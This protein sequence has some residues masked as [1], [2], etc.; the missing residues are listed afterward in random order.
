MKVL[1]TTRFSTTD[2]EFINSNLDTRWTVLSGTESDMSQLIEQAKDADAMLGFGVSKE[3]LNHAKQL[4][5]FQYPSA[6]VDR[7]D[8]SDFSRR[9]ILLC[10]SHSNSQVVAEHC[11]A[12]L[13]N[14]TR[15]ITAHH[16][17]A[18]KGLRYRFDGSSNDKNYDSI[19]LAGMKIGLLGFGHI[20]STV[21]SLLR[22]FKVEL[23][24]YVRPSRIS[25]KNV[26]SYVR[27]YAS[28]RELFSDV[29]V[30]INSLPLT[31][32][33]EGLI[34]DEL[35]GLMKKDALFINV[36]R[37]SVV[38]EGSLYRSLS[39]GIIKGAAIDVWYSDSQLLSDNYAFE[40]LDNLIISPYR[41]GSCSNT[42]THLVDA[43]MNLNRFISGSELSNIVD[44]KDG[45]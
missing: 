37:A 6:G 33:T 22:A 45:Y 18:R 31:R 25:Q 38:D 41:A 40:S 30:V 42:S 8:L 32:D 27:V 24:T 14:L 17:L 44:Y 10:N 3:L 34:G 35:F 21:S 20:G 15:K 5:L 4:K 26:P 43:V 7:L 1:L 29:D 39:M 2:R 13:L 23:S 36:G 16:E 11:L 28:I 12:L 9:K 19:S